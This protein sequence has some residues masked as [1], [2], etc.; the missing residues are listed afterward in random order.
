[1]DKFENVPFSKSNWCCEFHQFE[2]LAAHL[3]RDKRLKMESGYKMIVR[4]MQDQFGIVIIDE[5]VEDFAI[6]D[7]LSDSISFIE[8]ISCLENEIGIELPDDFLVF[9]TLSSAR[10]FSTKLDDYIACTYG[11]EEKYEEHCHG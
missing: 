8:F 9:E 2:P 5:N 11:S 1:M 3:A 10:G 7:Y 4:I 6:S